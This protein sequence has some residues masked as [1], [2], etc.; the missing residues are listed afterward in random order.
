MDECA[1]CVTSLHVC[2][3]FMRDIY[4]ILLYVSLIVSDVHMAEWSESWLLNL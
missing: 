1:W 4:T 2:C 3:Y